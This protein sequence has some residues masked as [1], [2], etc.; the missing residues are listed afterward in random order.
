MPSPRF[1]TQCGS[2]TLERRRPAGDDHHR[3]VC[4][5]CGHIHYENPKIITGCIIEQDGRYLLCQRAIAPRIGTWT[6]P[7]GF[8][9]NG[10]TT[11]E[12]AL[13]EV[14]EEAGVVAEIACPYSIFSVPAISE[15]YLIFRA[16]LLHDTG[17][18]GSETSARRFF[19]PEDIP[20]EQIYYPAIRQILER[21][22]AERE[23]GSYGIYMGSDD[24]G[25]VHF[26]R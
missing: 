1:C 13:R 15:V 5:G 6:L 16:R 4:A 9:E 8:M 20:W 12:A 24:T 3:L 23:T 17:Y 22:I 11:E 2:A 19:A 7:A 26:I 21:Y 18:F 10:E 25:K 14:R